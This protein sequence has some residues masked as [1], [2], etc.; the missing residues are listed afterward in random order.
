VETAFAT[1]SK[2]SRMTRLFAEDPDTRGSA[3]LN[4]QEASFLG[5]TIIS[6]H[7]G[8]IAHK[9]GQELLA[10]A[11]SSRFSIPQELRFPSAVWEL[12]IPGVADE[13][14]VG[15]YLSPDGRE[16]RWQNVEGSLVLTKDPL[17]LDYTRG[18]FFGLRESVF[19]SMIAT[20][21]EAARVDLWPRFDRM[22]QVHSALS[23]LRDG[24][25]LGPLDFFRPIDFRIY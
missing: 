4:N 14:F 1:E 15:G 3:P 8:N 2:P 16:P 13:P 24:S 19:K 7:Y 17:R 25:A 9:M 20:T 12:L 11:L 22:V 21:R 23:L 5:D 6:L 10:A 18:T